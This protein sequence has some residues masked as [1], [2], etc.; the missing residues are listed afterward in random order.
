MDERG[1]DGF[2]K[3]L[4]VVEVSDDLGENGIERHAGEMADDA[5]LRVGKREKALFDLVALAFLEQM[6]HIDGEYFS[7]AGQLIHPD[8]S[9]PFLDGDQGGARDTEPVGDYLL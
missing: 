3:L 2:L 6:R 9:L 4:G 8:F 1:G 5:G 7:Q